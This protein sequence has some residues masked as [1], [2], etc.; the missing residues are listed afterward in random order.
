MKNAIVCEPA[1]S[2]RHG[3][4]RIDLGLPD[5]AHALV[6]HEEYCAGL[7]LCGLDVM[8]L[9]SADAFPDSVF[10]EDTAVLTR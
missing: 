6:Q 10:V 8:R 5:Y 7:K 9:E 1:P 3:L 2:L 4:T